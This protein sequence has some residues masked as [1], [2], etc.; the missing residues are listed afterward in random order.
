M[1][2]GHRWIPYIGIV[3]VFANIGTADMVQA[4]A[5]GGNPIVTTDTAFGGRRVVKARR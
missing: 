4:L 3:T 1:I 2:H 5:D